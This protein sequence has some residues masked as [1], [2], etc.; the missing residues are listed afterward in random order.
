MYT[1]TAIA[2]TAARDLFIVQNV[3]RVID[4]LFKDQPAVQLLLSRQLGDDG[5]HALVARQRICAATGHEPLPE[6]SKY[7]S[8]HW[9]RAGDI[10]YRSLAGFLAFEFH[11]ELY[12]V[13]KMQFMRRTS[14][15]ADDAMKTFAENHIRPDEAA[16]RKEIVNWWLTTLAQVNV[17][18]RELVGEILEQDNLSQSNLNNFLAFEFSELWRIYG[19]DIDGIDVIYNKWRRELL[20]AAG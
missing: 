7:V 2:P 1:F 5:H 13:V 3:A 17:P 10:P 12:I 11:Y 16:H 4:G 19:C 15:V 6:I 9:E 14:V 20:G 18:L 8:E